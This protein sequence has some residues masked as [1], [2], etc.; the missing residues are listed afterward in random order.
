MSIHRSLV[1]RDRLRRHRNVLTRAERLA[2]LKEDGKW[3]EGMSVF[4]LSK[5][6]N[7]KIKVGK[8]KKKEKEKA[9]AAAGAVPGPA[10]AAAQAAP[11]AKDALTGKGTPTTKAAPAGAAKGAPAAAPP[12][13]DVKKPATKK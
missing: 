10:P 4:G 8:V 11:A 2:V 6:R 12:V 3:V 5:V 1:L 7:I 9:A 13:H